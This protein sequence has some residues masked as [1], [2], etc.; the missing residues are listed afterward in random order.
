MDDIQRFKLKL[1]YENDCWLWSGSIGSNGYGRFYFKRKSYLAHRAAYL[2]FNGDI[3]PTLDVCH[4][5]DIRNCVNPS[6]LFIGT[7]SENMKDCVDKKRHKPT[8][9]NKQKSHCPKGHEYSNENTWINSNG[10][11]WCKACNNIKA[12]KRYHARNKSEVP[13]KAETV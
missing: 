9:H 10:W 2:M 6:H 1:K 5:C 11:R 7:R 12:K 4:K 13:T 8:L 3:P